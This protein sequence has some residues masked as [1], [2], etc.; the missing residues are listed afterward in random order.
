[1]RHSLLEVEGHR[2]AVLAANEDQPGTPVVFIHGV[3]ASVDCWLPSLPP[4]WQESV[5]WY[6]LSLPGHDD[7][8][9][10]ENYR[11]EEITPEMFAIVHAGAIEQLVGREPVALVGWSTG[12]F[13]ALNL[14]VRKPHLVRSVLSLCGFA[15]GGWSSELNLLRWFARGG[16][17]R[18]YLFRRI[19]HRLATRRWFYDLMALRAAANRRACRSSPVWP[20][21]ADALFRVMSRHDPVQLGDVMGS[22]ADFDIRDDLPRI[23]APTLIVGGDRDPI[24]PLAHTH[25]IA[26]HIPHA[27]LVVLPNCGHMFF[28]EATDTYQRLLVDW[29]SRTA[30]G[31]FAMTN[32]ESR[33]TKEVRMTNLEPRSGLPPPANVSSG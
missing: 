32:D 2:L 19:I 14:A 27:E 10:P 11:R 17:F 7:S 29:M 18:R 33:M 6:S 30:D 5:R 12:G 15:R 13:A 25:E 16:R 21:S 1:M 9:L 4:G 20:A 24:I 22:L 26:E 23:T 8:R 3:M 28:A 31:N